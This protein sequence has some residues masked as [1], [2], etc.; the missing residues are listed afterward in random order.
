M[1]CALACWSRSRPAPVTIL[2]NERGRSVPRTESVVDALLWLGPSRG[3]SEAPPATYDPAYLEQL[4]FR[5]R[6]LKDV[7]G[8]DFS[9]AVE[10][11]AKQ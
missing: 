2:V 1:A 6:I 10:Q 5:A 11:A 3:T 8:V 4:R 9:D 7:F